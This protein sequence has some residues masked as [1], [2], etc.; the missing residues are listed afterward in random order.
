MKRC[1]RLN[2]EKTSI[3]SFIY[4]L[5]HFLDTNSF[6]LV[7]V[8]F[9]VTGVRVIICIFSTICREG[10]KEIKKRPQLDVIAYHTA[11]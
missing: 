11:S 6:I 9:I 4:I 8:L 7:W 10:N 2:L 1:N 5:F 3:M